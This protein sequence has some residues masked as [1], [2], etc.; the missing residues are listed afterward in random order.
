VEGWQW[1]QKAQKATASGS[2]GMSDAAND[3]SS[4]TTSEAAVLRRS[5]ELV[6][7]Y[8]SGSSGLSDGSGASLSLSA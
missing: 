8:A 4:T 1:F 5:M 6:R 2:D 3:T 7:A